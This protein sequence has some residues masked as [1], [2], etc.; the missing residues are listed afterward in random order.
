MGY[1]DQRM[2]STLLLV[3]TFTPIPTIKGWCTI[4]S[5]PPTR[6]PFTASPF[7]KPPCH[8]PLQVLAVHLH[9]DTPLETRR[10]LA[11]ADPYECATQVAFA[12]SP[13]AVS[14]RKVGRVPENAEGL[15]GAVRS[16]CNSA[17][18]FFFWGGGRTTFWTLQDSLH[19]QADRCQLAANQ[20]WPAINRRLLEVNRH[21]RHVDVQTRRPRCQS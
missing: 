18:I 21:R 2:S 4:L 10:D 15:L 13:P 9:P 6:T 1:P 17:Q 16:R 7:P 8:L 19:L 14:T 5:L 20:R 11:A 12:P 3:T